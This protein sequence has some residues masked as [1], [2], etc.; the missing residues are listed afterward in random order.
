MRPVIFAIA[1]RATCTGQ[2]TIS[3]WTLGKSFSATADLAKIRAAIDQ[4]PKAWSKVI[5][6]PCLSEIFGGVS[7]DGLKRA[8]K[9]YDPGHPNIEDLKRKTFFAIRR[10]PAALARG[11]DI[12]DR[13]EASYRAAVPLMRFLSKALG[14]AF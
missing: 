5:G 7:G 13:V 11:G 12:L 9:G 2:G 10:V 6:D 1:A 14:A 3:T 8:P 4:D